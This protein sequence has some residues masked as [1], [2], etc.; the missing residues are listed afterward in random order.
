[1]LDLENGLELEDLRERVRSYAVATA[2]DGSLKIL[3]RHIGVALALE[4]PDHRAAVLAWLRQWGCRGLDLASE[5]TSTGALLTWGDAWVT[6]LPDPARPLTELSSEEIVT[7]AVAYGQL[8]GA[9]AGIRHRKSGDSHVA[10]GPTAAAKTMYALRPNACAPWDRPIRYR[11]GLAENAAA[12]R[13]YLRLA[14][15]ALAKTA[16]RA[17]VAVENLP[18]LVGRPESS[19]PKI[20]DEYLWMRVTRGSAVTK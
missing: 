10:F 5:E 1:V 12:Y 7:M 19:P 3:R 17:G 14:A 11:L 2:Y 9:V 6:R 15:C 20:I 16:E 8:A 18:A 4:K 13:S